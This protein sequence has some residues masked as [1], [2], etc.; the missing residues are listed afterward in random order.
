MSSLTVVAKTHQ[1]QTGASAI[2]GSTTWQV[3]LSLASTMVLASW[4]EAVVH[5]QLHV[6]T[7]SKH[8]V[9]A[10]INCDTVVLVLSTV[11]G[12]CTHDSA[13]S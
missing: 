13:C 2:H 10:R 8:C 5:V 3:K 7:S 12:L 4:Q 9:A 11:Q 1:T 6:H